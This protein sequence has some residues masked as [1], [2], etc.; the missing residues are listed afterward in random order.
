MFLSFDSNTDVFE[1]AASSSYLFANFSISPHGERRSRYAVLYGISVSA[2]FHKNMRVLS[3][4]YYVF[5]YE[6]NI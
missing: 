5:P 4:I 2:S 1:V 3:I 6:I